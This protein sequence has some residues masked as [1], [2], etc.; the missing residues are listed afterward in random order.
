MLGI[1]KELAIFLVAFLDGMLVVFTYSALRV[2]RRI[3]KHNLFWVS[4][5]DI[6]F[7]VL[8]ALY[9]FSEISR[10]CSG[11]IRWYFIVG[12]L[13]GGCSICYFVQKLIKKYIDNSR[14]T[15]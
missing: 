8:M 1:E 2:F 3:I 9:L 15:R 7:W 6:I 10:V 12:V 13:L 14:K 4:V 5:E 11:S